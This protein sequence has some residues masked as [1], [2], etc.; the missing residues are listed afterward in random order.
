MTFW[1]KNIVNI[2]D[3]PL[4]VQELMEIDYLIMNRVPIRIM[5]LSF[6]FYT[7]KS[8]LLIILTFIFK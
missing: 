8:I 5:Y 1:L 7:S 6:I 4:V 3:L 2:K